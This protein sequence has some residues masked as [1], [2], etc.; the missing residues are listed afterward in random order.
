MYISPLYRA[1][2]AHALSW[3]GNK[4]EQ[5]FILS[6]MYRLLSLHDN[7]TY[8]EKTL[9]NMSASERTIW[10]KKVG[11]KLA[12]RFDLNNTHFVFLAGE[13]YVAPLRKHLGH[14]SEPMKGMVG[15]GNRISWLEK[16]AR[17]SDNSGT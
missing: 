2:L 6:A 12:E 3:A 14:Y 13:K 11:D 10:G 1:S 8:Y 5:V 7:I 4:S 9:G 17:S 15:I 16:N